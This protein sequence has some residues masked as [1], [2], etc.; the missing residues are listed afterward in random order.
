MIFYDILIIDNKDQ[1]EKYYHINQVKPF[2]SF[3][4]ISVMLKFASF[5]M[6]KLVCLNT[7]SQS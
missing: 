6:F 4:L 1:N 2:Q 3:T 5:I 7:S